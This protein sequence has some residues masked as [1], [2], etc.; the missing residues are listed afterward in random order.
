MRID[1]L[2]AVLLHIVDVRVREVL[3]NGNALLLKHLCH[4]ALE[5]QTVIE[6]EIRLLDFL[7]VGGLCDVEMWILTCGDDQLD[8]HIVARELFRHIL[9]K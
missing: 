9:Q 6:K 2:L 4:L 1:D 8:V 7:K 5:V 3:C